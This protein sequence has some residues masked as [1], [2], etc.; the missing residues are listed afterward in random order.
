MQCTR[1]L[2]IAAASAFVGMMSCA[3]PARADF[4]V[5]RPDV[6]YGAFEVETVGDA[7]F[8]RDARL[9]GERSNTVEV[10]YGVTSWWLTEVEAEFNRGPGPRQATYFN[11]LTSENLFAFT[12]RGERWIDVGLFAE[13]GQA[14]QRGQPSEITIGPVLR[15][16]IGEVSNSLNLF[17]TRDF[18]GAGVV[19]PTPIVAFETRFEGWTA[20]LS[21]RVIAA[22]GL[23]FYGQHGE[24]TPPRAWDM[25]DQRV[26]PQFFGKVFNV[27]PGTLEWNG[28]V[29]VGLTPDTPRW[30]VRW[31][32]EYE[33]H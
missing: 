3:V 16:D 9:R 31:Q 15:K 7:A 12:E 26:G 19:R 29:L 21:D 4:K 6:Q 14:L 22:P 30:T 24:Q 20:Q 28:G 10:E 5:W 33:F 1:R 23:Q 17:L 11:Q 8:D 32:L 13:Y 18:G 2:V 25:R 27:G